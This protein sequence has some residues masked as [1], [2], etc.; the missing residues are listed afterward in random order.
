MVF[1]I[2]GVSGVGKTS[3]GELIAKKLGYNFLDADNFHPKENIQ[4]MSQGIPLNDNDRFPWLKI[5]SKQIESYQNN[6]CGVVLACSALKESYRNILRGRF[7]EFIYLKVERELIIKR[8]N[9]RKNHFFNNLLIKS[10]FSILEEPK[11]NI[12]N[13]LAEES[14]KD[15]SNKVLILVNEIKNEK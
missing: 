11:E 4:K 12:I 8:L 14:I 15:V 7:V 13:I 10:Q 3:V 6:E 5:L 2:M 1:I 9:D